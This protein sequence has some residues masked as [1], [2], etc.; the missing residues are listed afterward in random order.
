MATATRISWQILRQRAE[1]IIGQAPIADR[2]HLAAVSRDVVG[3]LQELHLYRV[4][5]EVQNQDLREAQI[6]LAESRDRYADLY[7]NAP[8]GYLTVGA[9]GAITDV[10]RTALQWLGVEKAALIGRRLPQFASP[11]D[12]DRLHLWW[13][14]LMHDGASPAIEIA[15]RRGD[16]GARCL[17]VDGSI[18]RDGA[19]EPVVRVALTDI[20]LRKR[21]EAQLLD[22]K[23]EADRAN[24]A[25]SVF[26]SNASHELRTPLN[27]I[28]GFAQ[29]LSTAAEEAGEELTRSR[30]ESM[31]AAGRHLAALVDQLLDLSLSDTGKLSVA[32][33]TVPVSPYLSACIEQ[34]SV[35]AMAQGIRIHVAS[36]LL[37]TDAMR[38]DP[39]R[40]R[41]V[42]LNFL[43]NAI[44]YGGEEEAICVHA[45]P[46]G[47]AG[48]VRIAVTDHGAGIPPALQPHVFEP[49]NRLGKETSAKQ[50]LGIGLAIA[51]ELV[52]LMGGQIG[53][54]SPPGAG[55]TFW[56]EM[57]RAVAAP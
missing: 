42:L 31:L 22:A 48:T 50:G 4:E 27:A 18:S 49:F 33:V 19:G 57:P 5:L 8:N 34:I 51:K 40:L 38:G 15:L 44:K 53:F 24:R 36:D 52:E 12:A 39:T 16:D 17:Q 28:V 21:A 43:T 25:K 32:A 2:N 41:E 13:R 9:Q 54:S 29:V 20:T 35:T 37:A 1:A 11:E 46:G 56:F 7:D 55:C 30:L 3:L 10:N 47:G 6:S 14:A 26:L 23:S 45:G